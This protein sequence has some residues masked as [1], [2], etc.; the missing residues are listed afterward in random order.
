MMKHIAPVFLLFIVLGFGAC[1]QA[2]QPDA[3]ALNPTGRVAISLVTPLARTILPDSGQFASVAQYVITISG[4]SPALNTD[5][6]ATLSTSAD[7]TALASADR[8]S[9]V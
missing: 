4:G 7:K 5:I 6:T 2:A 8:K 1:R 3:A 9:V